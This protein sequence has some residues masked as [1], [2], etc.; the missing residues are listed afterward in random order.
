MDTRNRIIFYM[1]LVL[2]SG[3]GIWFTY[4]FA[5][6][7]SEFF[8]TLAYAAIIIGLF[9]WFDTEVLQGIQ[10]IQELKRKGPQQQGNI[11]YAI[12]LLAFAVLIHAVATLVG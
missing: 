6:H 7:F 11:A 1:T 3:V 8:V 5:I 4:N 12:F 10:T 9:D 2:V